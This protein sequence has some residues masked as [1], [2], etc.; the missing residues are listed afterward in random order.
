MIHD[1]QQ[2]LPSLIA[3]PTAITT[4][5]RGDYLFGHALPTTI[6]GKLVRDPRNLIT[7]ELIFSPILFAT[8]VHFPSVLLLHNQG[9][10]KVCPDSLNLLNAGDSF[11]G[12]S[13]LSFRSFVFPD[14]GLNC[15]GL[16]SSRVF[17]VR[18]PELSLFQLSELLHFIDFHK[19]FIKIQN[20][21]CLNPQVKIYKLYVVILSESL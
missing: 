6:P 19:K 17:S 11:A 8:G 7:V 13:S 2:F 3:Q 20:Q 4:N 18:F 21:F 12:I 10:P 14:Q 1:I 5:H 15:F 9:Y 16:E